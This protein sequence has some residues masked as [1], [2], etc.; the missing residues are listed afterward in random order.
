MLWF[1]QGCHLTSLQPNATSPF[2]RTVYPQEVEVSQQ[3]HVVCSVTTSHLQGHLRHRMINRQQ[4]QGS[5]PHVP[6]GKSRMQDSVV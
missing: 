5:P 3:P 2:D 1:S 6:D 4:R